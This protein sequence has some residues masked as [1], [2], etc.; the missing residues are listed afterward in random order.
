MTRGGPGSARSLEPILPSPPGNDVGGEALWLCP[1]A[2]G[3]K[4]PV[5]NTAQLPDPTWCLALLLLILL[6]EL[7]LA[8]VQHKLERGKITMNSEPKSEKC[9]EWVCVSHG[10]GVL[11]VL[12]V[13]ALGD[14]EHWVP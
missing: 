5:L 12:L 11:A 10:T 9:G 2:T 8:L 13:P 6:L 14:Q 4:S 1:F 3:S 7:R